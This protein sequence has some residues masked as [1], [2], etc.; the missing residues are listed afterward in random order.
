MTMIAD[1]WAELLAPGLRKLFHL[2]MRARDEL[3]KRTEIY[4]V[5]TSQRAYEDYLGIGEL[6]TE[7]WNEFEKTGRTSYDGFD[8]GWKTRLEHREF[9]KGIVIQRKLMEDNLYP[10]AGIP[11]EV[12]G[13]V[14]KLADSAAVH[15]EK[16]GAEL[17]TNAFTDTGKDAEGFSIGGADGVGLCSAAHVNSPSIATT[18]SNKFELALNGENLT[19]VRHA[20]RKFKDDRGELV[21]IKP[22]LLLVPPELEET[23]LVEVGTQLDP[24]SANN[25]INVNKGRFQVVS[26]DYLTDSNAWFMIDSILKS[27]HLVWLDRIAPEFQSQ[28]DFDTYQGKFA[29]YHR[30]SRGFDDWRF[31]AGSNPS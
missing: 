23:A 19:A 29:G 9:T 24:N 6:G 1:N 31:I 12:T 7:G 15:R 3:F 28:R 20:M 18:Q 16:A 5:D 21:S 13:Q 8:K 2:R 22:D 26:W 4:P 11:K 27:Q 25:A 17:F 10:D 14:E 30:F